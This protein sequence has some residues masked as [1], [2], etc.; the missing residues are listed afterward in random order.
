MSFPQ[1][2]ARH[3]EP[4]LVTLP[5]ELDAHSALTVGM[6]LVTALRAGSDVVVADATGTTFCDG[7]GARMLAEAHGEAIA[8]RAELRIA[9]SSAV[10][11]VLALTGLDTGLAL[12][13]TVSAAVTGTPPGQVPA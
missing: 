4:V 6:E 9:V 3:M 1:L 2:P 8:A 11:R 10:L 5:S 12:Y 13:L 7:A